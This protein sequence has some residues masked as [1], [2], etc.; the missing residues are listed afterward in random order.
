MIGGDPMHYFLSGMAGTPR[1]AEFAYNYWDY[2]YRGL[3]SLVFAAKALGE[4]GIVERGYKFIEYFES[5]TGDTGRGDPDKL[6]KKAKSK[7]A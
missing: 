2:A 4:A 6:N 5:T 7:N 1:Q 3:I